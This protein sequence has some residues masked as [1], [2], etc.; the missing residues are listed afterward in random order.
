[1][2]DRQNL[3]EQRQ[4]KLS[5]LVLVAEISACALA[6]VIGEIVIVHMP[7]SDSLLGTL[8]FFYP[9]FCAGLTCLLHYIVTEY[10]SF[11]TLTLQLAEDQM[12]SSAPTEEIPAEVTIISSQRLLE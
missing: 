11:R 5:N 6:I 2:L 10:L 1:M 4:K 3:I 8:F 7:F 12:Y 9:V